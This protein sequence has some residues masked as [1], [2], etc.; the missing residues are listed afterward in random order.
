MFIMIDYSPFWETLEKSTENWYTLTTRHKISHSTLSR[1]KN[2][3]N[4]SMQT[5]NDLCRILN[6]EISDICK[7]VASCND[8]TL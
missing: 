3:K 7:Y 5:I 8:Q 4:I 2:N 6:C 1:L